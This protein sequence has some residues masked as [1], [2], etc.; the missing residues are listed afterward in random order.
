MTFF[1]YSTSALAP[2]SWVVHFYDV[3]NNRGQFLTVMQARFS[4][5]MEKNTKREENRK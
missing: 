3:H 1:F 2:M 5:K 4:I